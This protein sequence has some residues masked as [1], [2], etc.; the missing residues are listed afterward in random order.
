MQGVQSLLP[1]RPVAAKPVIYF[2]ER[3]GAKTVDPPLRLLASLDEPR[4]PQHSQVAGDARA[5]D[6]QQRRQLTRGRRA[7]G[8]RLQQ[9]PPALVGDRPENS[10]HTTNVPS[11][12]RNCQGK[13]AASSLGARLGVIPTL[14]DLRRLATGA[15]TGLHKAPPA[16]VKVGDTPNSLRWER[17]RS[18]RGS[19]SRQNHERELDRPCRWRHGDFELMIVTSD[20]RQHVVAPSPAAMTA[21]VAIAQADTVLVW[22]R[23]AEV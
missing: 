8:Q 18:E 19:A 9:R 1:Q 15:T 21:L 14:R 20:D 4:F 11:W 3:C 10:F 12:L 23:R 22:T 17:A 6:R 7:A 5:S 16:V 13:Y 2:C